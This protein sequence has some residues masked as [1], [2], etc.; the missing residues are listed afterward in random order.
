MTEKNGAKAPSKAQAVYLAL[1]ELGKEAKRGEIREFVRER[2]GIDMKPDHVS[3]ARAEALRKMAGN[4]KP[5]AKEAPPAAVA[6]PAAPREPARVE[7][8][9]PVAAVE[10]PLRGKP[11]PTGGGTAVELDDLLALKAL[12]GRVGAENL[13]RLID[14][15]G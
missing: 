13:R 6:E 5:A 1:Q 11:A 15:V 10:T 4:G 8:A 14:V 12:V 7:Q 3:T 2:F 9:A